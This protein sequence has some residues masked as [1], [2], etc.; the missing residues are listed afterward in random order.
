MSALA[1]EM[2]LATVTFCHRRCRHGE[3]GDVIVT[4]QRMM[5]TLPLRGRGCYWV[6]EEGGGEAAAVVVGRVS[7]LYRLLPALIA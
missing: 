1:M 5:Q 3:D 4:L 6:R 7:Y 2:V